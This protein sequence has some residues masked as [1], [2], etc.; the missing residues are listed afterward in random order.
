MHRIHSSTASTSDVA[1]LT[2][3]QVA[4]WQ[5]RG[6]ALVN[7]L[8]PDELIHAALDEMSRDPPGPLSRGHMFPSGLSSLNA[9]STHPRLRAV[10]SQLLGTSALTLLQ[11]EAWSKVAPTLTTGLM[12]QS[13]YSNSDQRMHMDY[14][15]HYLTHPATWDEPEAVA[16]ILY[17]DSEEDCGGATRV[18]ARS[19]STDAAYAWPYTSMPGTGGHAWFNDRESAEGYY[20][21]AAPA[22]ARFRR[23]LYEREQVATYQPGTV[24]LYRY[25]TWHRGTP[26]KRGAPNRRVLNFVIAVRCSSASEPAAR[27]HP[28]Q[29]P[30][31]VA[32]R[33]P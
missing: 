10:A 29:C 27:K 18:V 2:A 33:S 11:S 24:L 13:A 15:N 26:L 22:V 7:G 3:E 21:K 16:G 31:W 4:S 28:S 9:I 14:P 20:E 17:F 12:G 30:G 6:F 1:P 5:D 32:S 23:T 8:L 19:G 25:D